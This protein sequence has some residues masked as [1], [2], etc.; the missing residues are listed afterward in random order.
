VICLTAL[1]AEIASA[2][3]GGDM[4]VCRRFLKAPIYI[5]QLF[6]EAAPWVSN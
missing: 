5:I 1:K 3:R 2:R 4:L 6:E